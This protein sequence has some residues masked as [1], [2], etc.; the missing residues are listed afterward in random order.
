MSFFQNNANSLEREHRGR[1]AYYEFFDGYT[2]VFEED[3]RGKT[4]TKRIYTEDY[5]RIKGNVRDRILYKMEILF[6]YLFSVLLFVRC[7]WMPMEFN[8]KWYVVIAEAAFLLLA[9]REGLAVGGFVFAP[10]QLQIGAY[11]SLTTKMRRRI[12]GAGVAAGGL[13][14]IYLIYVSYTQVLPTIDGVFALG[15][16]VSCCLT[17]MALLWMHNTVQY[18]KVYNPLKGKIQ[19]YK[20][21]A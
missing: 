1:R 16:L 11:K 18:E 21:Y 20:I 6:M 12:I 2:E 14:L 10:Q 4:R 3:A 5:F 7:A 15:C 17:Q 8:T 13:I 19:G 9:V